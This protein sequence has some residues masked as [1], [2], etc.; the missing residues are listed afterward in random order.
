MFESGLR[1]II[2][3]PITINSRSNYR[4]GFEMNHYHLAR[5]TVLG[6]LILIAAMGWVD[7]L[8]ADDNNQSWQP[9]PPMPDDFDWVQMTSG[10]WL[11][12]EIIAMYKDTL[13]FDSDEFDMQMLDWK[14]IREIRS[15]QTVRV[16][17]EDDVI[18][19]GKLLVEGDSIRVIGEK[20][21]V[22]TRSLVLS[23]TAGSPKEKNFWSGNV[24]A[25]LNLRAGNTEQTEY[26]A[27]AHLSR[28]TPKNRINFDYLGSFIENDGTT[29]ADSQRASAGWNRFISKRFFVSPIYGDYYRDPFQ[30]IAARWSVGAGVG[31]Q[32]VDTSKVDLSVKFGIGYQTTNFDDVVEGEVTSADTP[33]LAVGTRYDDELTGWMDYFFDFQFFVVNEESGKYT[34]HL[35]TGFE[36]DIIGDLEFNVSIVW[37]RIQDPR[38]NSDGTYPEKD[39]YRTIFGINYRF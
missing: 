18:A 1:G 30:N 4:G 16:A 17:F 23:I 27:T 39:D 11:K 37:D 5:T 19:T 25:G 33:A 38:Q 24:G 6:V 26:N 29:I 15:A 3:P 21:Y 2:D 7:T 9:P 34:H 20:E 8:S 13:E 35:I 22:S 32:I 12:G 31:Y 10:E 14:D 28:R 36:F